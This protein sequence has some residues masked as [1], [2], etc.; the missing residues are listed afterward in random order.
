VAARDRTN[1][2]GLLRQCF[3]KWI[4][5]NGFDE[6]NLHVVADKLNRRPRMTLDWDSPAERHGKL[7]VVTAA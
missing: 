3:S 4:A 5:L 1:T 7:V 2:N 6:V